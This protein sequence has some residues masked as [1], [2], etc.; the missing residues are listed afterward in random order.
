[1]G[2]S[3]GIEPNPVIANEYE[4]DIKV[5]TANTK[6]R[7]PSMKAGVSLRSLTALTH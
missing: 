3:S 5:S 1:M 6:K 7:D 2:G 4:R